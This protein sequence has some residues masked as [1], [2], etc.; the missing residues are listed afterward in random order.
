MYFEG[1]PQSIVRPLVLERIYSHVIGIAVG[2]QACLLDV[3]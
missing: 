1:A 3:A 2:I